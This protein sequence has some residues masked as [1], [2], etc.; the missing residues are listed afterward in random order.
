MHDFS[1]NVYFVLITYSFFLVVGSHS[2]I[3]CTRFDILISTQ[4]VLSVP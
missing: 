1:S 2:F 4:N 3:S